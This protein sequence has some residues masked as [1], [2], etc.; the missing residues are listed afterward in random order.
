MCLVRPGGHAALVPRP[1]EAATT[2]P[3]QGQGRLLPK[4]CSGVAV[5]PMRC[6]YTR[7]YFSISSYFSPS[8]A[9]LIHLLQSRSLLC[10]SYISF[11][12]GMYP[13]NTGWLILLQLPPAGRNHNVRGTTS[14]FA[15]IEIL[16]DHFQ[17]TMP[18]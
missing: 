9:L 17:N 14:I 10:S 13:Q 8:I 7:T 4:K 12:L 6:I 15:C 11:L 3:V 5:S 1:V 16:Q 2:T 18:W